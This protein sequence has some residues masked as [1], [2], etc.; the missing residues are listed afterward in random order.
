M[1]AGGEA[2]GREG[3]RGSAGGGGGGGGARVRLVV[4]GREYDVTEWA[5]R[6]PGGSLVFAGAGGDVTALFEAHHEP[7][8]VGFLEKFYVGEAPPAP[9]D[10]PASSRRGAKYASEL[11]KGQFYRV[12]KDRVAEHF[13]ATGRDPCTHP[14]MVAKAVLIL[15]GLAACYWGT[16]FSSTPGGFSARLALAALFG[17]FKAEVGV[18]VQHDA[19]H[20]TG[21]GRR[22]AWLCDAVGCALDAVGASSFMWKQQH[23]VGHHPYTNTPLDPDIRVSD[24]DVRRV[25]PGQPWF[26]YHRFQHLYLGALYGLLSLKSVL[27]DDFKSLYDGCIG[28]VELTHMRGWERRVFWGGKVWFFSVW[29][30]APS[31]GSSLPL[32]QLAA[33]WL[34]A[35]FVTGWMLAFL[36]QVAHVSEGVAWPELSPGGKV[37]GRSEK[38]DALGWARTQ[39]ET[40]RNFCVDSWFWM[41][42]SGGLNMQIEHHLFPWV[43]HCHYRDIAP[44]VR[45]TCE[46]FGVQYTA[47]DSYWSAL[48]AHFSHLRKEG[49]PTAVPGLSTVG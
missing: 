33:L 37:R 42:F 5:P 17:V 45:A 3:A 29:F 16:F 19:N 11:G 22:P 27:L 49:F 14:E 20:G 6:H 31:V 1:G 26:P 8:V 28:S 36:F 32:G 2:R 40:T 4:R 15:A 7:W 48:R 25:A 43:C 9:A 35:E 23:V 13:K 10:A 34:L 38:G 44:L 24:R 39:V 12:L 21:F 41:H 18:S 47:Y 30:L 46:E